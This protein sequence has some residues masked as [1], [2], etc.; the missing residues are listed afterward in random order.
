MLC[1]TSSVRAPARAAAREASVPAC[2]P[3]ITMTSYARSL[4]NFNQFQAVQGARILVAVTLRC[5]WNFTISGC[6]SKIARCSSTPRIDDGL[7]ARPITH[8]RSSCSPLSALPAPRRWSSRSAASAPAPGT[9]GMK[10]RCGTLLRPLEPGRPGSRRTIELARCRRTGP[11]PE[12]RDRPVRADCRRA[13][14]G[15]RGVLCGLLAAP[16]STCDAI[17]TSCSSTSAARASHR[18]WIARSTTRFRRG[19]YSIERH[20]RIHQRLP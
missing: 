7:Q 9:P 20:D 8:H 19:Q 13:G 16:S 10:A 18:A 3:P 11:E 4:S 12:S 2:P 6:L 14:A 15:L 17:A 1:V 5:H